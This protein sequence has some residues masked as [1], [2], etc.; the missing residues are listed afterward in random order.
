VI[1]PFQ[2][3]TGLLLAFLVVILGGCARKSEVPLVGLQ[4]LSK[5]PI[6]LNVASIE[7]M[8]D[9]T[10]SDDDFCVDT[11]MS[12]SPSEIVQ[13]WASDRFQLRGTKGRAVLVI[14]EASLKEDP[15]PLDPGNFFSSPLIRYRGNL[16]I[17]LKLFSSDGDRLGTA[18]ASA[19]ASRTASES[20]TVREREKLWICLVETLLNQLD[21]VLESKIQEHLSDFQG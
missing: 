17:K 20:L 11:L 9:Y 10:P 7:V 12:P 3:R 6:S 16:V 15:V 5:A 8:N 1:N 21:P 19:S 13:Q 4:S 18:E 2:R 14:E